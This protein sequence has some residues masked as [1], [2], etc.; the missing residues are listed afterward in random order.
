M[1]VCFFSDT[2]PKADRLVSTLSALSGLQPGRT[3]STAMQSFAE[4]DAKLDALFRDM[5]HTK[6]YL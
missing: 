3:V 1:N 6:I 5:P 2:A 4:P